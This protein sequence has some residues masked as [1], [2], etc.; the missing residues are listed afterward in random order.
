MRR[1]TPKQPSTAKNKA[2]QWAGY[3][4]SAVLAM[5]DRRMRKERIYKPYGSQILSFNSQE[6]ASCCMMTIIH[7]R[8]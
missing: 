6:I 3:L 5:T 7:Q 4:L 8:R 2:S 1:S